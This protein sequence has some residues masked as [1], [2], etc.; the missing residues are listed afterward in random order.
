MIEDL[1]YGQSKLIKNIQND[2]YQHNK[3]ADILLHVESRLTCSVY[4]NLAKITFVRP[5]L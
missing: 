3:C 1:Q 5:S 2:K 4:L